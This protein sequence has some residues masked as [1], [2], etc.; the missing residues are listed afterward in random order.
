MN[1]KVKNPYNSH[2]SQ[3]YLNL[4]PVKT[5]KFFKEKKPLFFPISPLYLRKLTAN[6]NCKLK[7]FVG[8]LQLF[9]QPQCRTVLCGTEL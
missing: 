8:Y 7:K 9:S 1:L 5:S 2:Y 3:F 6:L 4:F